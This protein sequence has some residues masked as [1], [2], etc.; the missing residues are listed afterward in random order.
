MNPDSPIETVSRTDAKQKGALNKLGLKT[1][2]DILYHFPSRYA[3][4]GEITTIDKLSAGEKATIYGQINKLKTGK[5]FRK[6]I[7]MAD[8]EISDQTGKIKVVWFNQPY[9]AKLIQNGATVKLSGKVTERNGALYL[10]NPEIETTNELPIDVGDSLFGKKADMPFIPIYP[11]S[12][13]ITSRWFYHAIQKVIQSGTLDKIIDPVPERILAKYHLPNLKT[14]LIWIH[15]PKKEKHRE[16]AR[17]RFAFEEIFF[18][19]L[20]RQL[21]RINYARHKGFIIDKNGKEVMEFT[22]RFPFGVT[23]GQIRSIETILADFR[24]GQPMSRLLEGDVGSGKTA[25]AATTAFAVV[26]TRP[27]KQSFGTLQTAYMA[28]T[29]ILA[30]QHF[31]SF[32]KYFRHLPI[33]IG[34]ITGSGCRKFPS[35]INPDGWTD[36]SRAQLLKWVKNG[37]IAILLGTHALIQKSVEFKNLAYI[38]IDEQH[39][40]GTAQRQKLSRKSDPLPHLLSMTATPIPRTLALTIYGDLDLSLL[41]E[42]P[43][44]R[45]PVITEIIPPNKRE[46]AYEKI[47]GELTA[48]RQAYV[49]CPRI[50]EPDPEKEMA[51]IAKSVKAEAER[52]GREIFPDYAIDILHSKMTPK[53][54]ERV[55]DDF[56]RGKINILVATSVVEVGV[57]VPN[58]TVII[59]EGA[60]RF[61]LSQLHQLRGR[62]I[63]ST[64]QPYCFIFSETKTEKSIARL[65]ALVTAKN[66][67]ELSE[68]DLA[69]RGPGELSGAKQWGISDLGMEAIKNIKMVEAAREEARSLLKSDSEFLEYPILKKELS[70]RGKDIH[71]E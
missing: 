64:R 4:L 39:R 27:G 34:L 12:R 13:G 48:G 16:M 69:L 15:S 6:K 22:E 31:E 61:G 70:A 7:A 9:I 1:A 57:N 8:G 71:F 46:L 35:K 52:L 65:K 26:A 20:A 58:A 21:E 47:R 11:E 66:G 42:M 28:P 53:E 51:I 2:R 41:D 17:K 55:M 38:I 43:P 23:R 24:S 32:I 63:R 33:Q 60:E 10:A 14:A 36:I 37:E 59:I 18:I 68:L 40:F 67:F 44:G 54:K 62:V 3:D 49:I 29:E 30:V 50:N 19:Q 56:S 45:K 25:V 5:A